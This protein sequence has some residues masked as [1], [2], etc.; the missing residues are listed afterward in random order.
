M[1]GVCVISQS[2]LKRANRFHS[3]VSAD[4]F[5]RDWA[6]TMDRGVRVVVVGLLIM[7]LVSAVILV[8]NLID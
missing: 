5:L 2:A 1:Y 3:S 4:S 6:G 8:A 7:L